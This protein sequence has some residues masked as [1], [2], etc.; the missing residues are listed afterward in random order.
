MVYADLHTHT[1]FSDGDLLPEQNVRLAAQ[2]G[3][4]TLAIAD[5]DSI[6]GIERA[7]VEAE[8]FGITIV[9]A[10]EISTADYHILGYNFDRTEAFKDFV[11]YSQSCVLARTAKKVEMLQERGYTISMDMLREGPSG[12]EMLGTYNIVLGLKQFDPNV[13]HL[14]PQTIYKDIVK[15]LPSFDSESPTVE[16]VVQA[17]H[18]ANGIVVFAHPPRD[19]QSIA[20]VEAVIAAGVDGL[21]VQPNFYDAKFDVTYLEVEALA[22]KHN[23][24]ITVGSDYHGPGVEKRPMLKPGM[25]DIDKFW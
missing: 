2:R 17:V 9:P 7:M 25:Y 3:L 24:R 23:L 8:K 12:Q 20:E 11:A 4:E 6:A 10:V 5:H 21:E 15:A 19:V 1:I 18:D 14:T 16:G 22:K 13:R